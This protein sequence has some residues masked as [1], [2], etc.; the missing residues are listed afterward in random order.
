[1]AAAPVSPEVA[2]TIVARA[3]LPPERAVHQPRHHLHGEVLEGERR[4]VKQLEQPGRRRNLPERRD[5][6]VM[7]AGIGLVEHGFEVGRARIA[8]EIGAHD[9]VCGLRIVEAGECFDLGGARRG[10]ASGMV[11]PPSRARPA[12]NAPS[13]GSAGASPL[14]L[15][16]RKTDL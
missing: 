14:V 9:A 10:Q 4:P 6:R 13:K 11:R 5:G 15:T 16:Y 8:L 12:S 3:P 1:M 7:E 2:P